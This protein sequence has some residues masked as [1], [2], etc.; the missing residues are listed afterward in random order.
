MISIIV[1]VYNVKKYLRTCIESVL[2]QTYTDWE[3]LLVDDGSKDS[4]GSICDYYAAQDSRIHAMH[5]E[6]GGVSTARNYG[7]ENAKGA[8]IM[9]VDSDDMLLPHA[10]DF[11]MAHTEGVE[12]VC[13]ECK[14]VHEDG[15][16]EFNNKQTLHNPELMSSRDYAER[17]LSYNTLCGPVCKLISKDVIDTA[18]F[19][20]KL[21][22]GEDAQFLVS[23]LIKK[24]FKVYC[25]SEII[26]KY[27]ILTNSLSHGNALMQISYIK[28]LISYLHYRIQEV[29]IE[30]NNLQPAV[31][32]AICF[33]YEEILSLQDWWKHLD[34]D[35]LEDY[36]KHILLMK[37][38]YSTKLM[39]KAVL[40][41]YS[42]LG[43]ILTVCFAPMQIK[44]VVKKLLF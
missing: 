26:Y 23:L 14:T 9:F 41:N 20:K 30:N 32:Y 33:N 12:M 5:K 13:C 11:C 15:V 8:W 2:A 1:P 7:L 18:H 21:H 28:E 4:S 22:K 31:A 34:H 16:T 19:E 35:E 3:L 17:I 43:F 25:S 44:K 27:R 42:C 24:D 39:Q 36:R 10:L 37:K 29:D 6:N 38:K 40:R